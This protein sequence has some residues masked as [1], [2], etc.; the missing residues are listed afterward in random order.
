MAP[1]AKA[2]R[3][4]PVGPATL[5][6]SARATAVLAESAAHRRRGPLVPVATVEPVVRVTR[7]R[8]ELSS[9]SLNRERPEAPVEPVVEVVTRPSAKREQAVPA[10]LAVL[11][12]LAEWV[13]TESEPAALR[14]EPQVTVEPVAKE[15]AP[16]AETQV[17]EVSAVT[18]AQPAWVAAEEFPAT[19]VTVV[20]VRAVAMAAT[21]VAQPQVS[22]ATVALVA[23]RRTVVPGVTEEPEICSPVHRRTAEMVEPVGLLVH[24][25]EAVARPKLVESAEQPV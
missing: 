22:T 8:R 20:R 2:A 15:E 6:V 9:L 19:V 3:A 5:P 16:R 24:R 4:V 10:E 11:A 21:V 12:V 1:G 23:T 25:R 13:T 18:A 17:R 14:E 7:V